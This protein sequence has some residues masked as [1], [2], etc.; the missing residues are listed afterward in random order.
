[1]L[2]ERTE[3]FRNLLFLTDLVIA[4]V[5]YFGLYFG[6]DI[7]SDLETYLRLYWVVLTGWVILLFT[8][9]EYHNLRVQTYWRVALQVLVNGVLFF[10]FCTSMSFLLH[11]QFASRAFLALYAVFTVLCFLALRLSV[12]FAANTLRRSGRNARNILL[13][14]TGRRAQEFISLVARHREWGYRIVG[15]LDNDD[16]MKGKSVAG[17]PCLGHISELPEVLERNVIDEVIMVVPRS[18]LKEIEHCILYCEAVGIP[19]TLST[20]FFDLE[21]AHGVPR[22]VDGFTYITFE[23]NRL[24]EEELL[25][26]RLLDILFSFIALVLLSP[27]F[28][29]VAIAIK[30]DSKGPVFFRQVRCTKNGRHFVLYKFRSMVAGA[31]AKREELLVRNEMS[32]PVFKI[33]NDP[34]VTRVGRFLR[35][36]SLDETPQFWNVLKGHMSLVGP[37]PPIPDEVE[38]YEPWQRRRLSMKPGITCIWQVSGRNQIDFEDWM[39][40]DLQYIDRW[41]L[42]LDF[43]IILQT[44]RAV[45]TTRGAK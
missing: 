1:M 28:L 11:L 9:G 10:G 20:D 27:V 29:A 4:T 18:W 31:E 5:I 44:I 7:A 40:L 37:R 22:E 24:K 3:L 14:G 12:L 45:V 2:K 23:T 43:R 6:T 19:T 33:S 8:R 35:R 15:L 39:K 17:Y 38:K 26:K 42:W 25:I 13:V 32:G 16:Q 41:S 21:I 34:R 36:T 30:L